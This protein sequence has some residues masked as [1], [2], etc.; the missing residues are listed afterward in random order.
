MVSL[1]IAINDHLSNNFMSS[2]E[3]PQEVHNIVTNTQLLVLIPYQ[4]MYTSDV[5]QPLSHFKSH[6]RGDDGLT[7]IITAKALPAIA[8]YLVRLFCVSTS[9]SGFLP[10]GRKP[11]C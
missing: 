4:C 11:G 2:L 9:L 1:L 10:Q 3:T 5:I 8:P 6:A 7:H